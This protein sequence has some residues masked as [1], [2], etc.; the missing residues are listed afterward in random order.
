MDGILK[1]SIAILS[2]SGIIHSMLNR[3]GNKMTEFEKAD[4]LMSLCLYMNGIC[5][6]FALAMVVR[7]FA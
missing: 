7:Y 6:G 5:M 3:K 2:N 1:F 4:K